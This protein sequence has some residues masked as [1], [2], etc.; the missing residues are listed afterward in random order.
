MSKLKITSGKKISFSWN[1][2]NDKV[3][4]SSTKFTAKDDGLKSMET[5]VKGAVT[6]SVEDRTEKNFKKMSYPKF[7]IAKS[8]KTFKFTY[9]ISSSKTLLSS[10]KFNKKEDC[11]KE[12]EK[13]KQNVEA[14]YQEFL[15]E[16]TLDEMEASAVKKAPLK[17]AKSLSVGLRKLPKFTHKKASPKFASKKAELSNIDKMNASGTAS[18]RTSRGK[19]PSFVNGKFSEEKVLSSKKALAALQSLHHT[20]GFKNAEQEFKEVSVESVNIGRKTTFYRL[21]QY[22]EG[23]PVFG[24]QL[25]VSA[26]E[27]GNVESLSGHYADI[28]SVSQIKFTE[29]MAQE[30]VL[31]DS[32]EENVTLEGLHYYV[33][34]KDKSTLCWKISTT[35]EA[36]FV[37]VTNGSIVKKM[38]TV[39][40]YGRIVSCTGKNLY[41]KEVE[42]PTAYSP[43]TNA[44]SLCDASR[45]ITIYRSQKALDSDGAV[46]YSSSKKWSGEMDA[47]SAFT[48]MIEI[49]DFY[50]SVL[51]RKGADNK[52]K[53]IHVT[54]GYHETDKTYSN[55]F[56]SS[57]STDT[58]IC[59]G[60]GNNYAKPIDVLGHEFTHAVNDSIWNPAYENESGALDEAFADIMGECIQDGIFDLHREDCTSGANR[61][62]ENPGLYGDP[63][64]YSKKEP[65]AT[66]PTESNDYGGVHSNSG[67]INHVAYLMQKKWPTDS[68]A[69]EFAALF[70]KSM[71]YLST[72]SNFLDFRSAILKAAKTMM[73]G[74]SKERAIAE[75]L[76]EVEVVYKDNSGSGASYVLDGYIYDSLNNPIIDAKI[77]MY[78][79]SSSSVYH[80]DYTDSTGRYTLGFV[81]GY[82][83][84]LVVTADGFN[85]YTCTVNLTSS[86]CS[87]RPRTA[88]IKLTPKST[89]S[90]FYSLQG[91][92]TNSETRKVVPGAVVKI[93][94]GAGGMQKLCADQCDVVLTTDED[95]KFFTSKLSNGT[96]SVYF[97]KSIPAEKQCF[98]SYCQ[99]N[100][101][102]KTTYNP[103]VVRT[104]RYFLSSIHVASRDK[105]ADAKKALPSTEILIDRDLNKGSGGKYIYASCGFAQ[106]STPITNIVL[107]KS[108]SKLTWTTKTF[109]S[110]GVSATYT[111]INVDLNE[112]AKGDY[113]Y[114]CY[115]TSSLFSPITGLSVIYDSETLKDPWTTVKW[116]NSSTE[117]D[118]NYKSPKGNPIYFIIKR[119]E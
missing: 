42:F 10:E 108:S 97:Y 56:Y 8:A 101:T 26:D 104:S 46:V 109:S 69:G 68:F 9:A 91:T 92:V 11:L 95:G 58:R 7:V 55:A 118:A 1:N 62:F 71:F 81:K 28:K 18:F 64:R 114:L 4:A 67:I 76:D 15:I 36:Y 25:V 31:K 14:E 6:A 3:V 40:D 107:V 79:G 51:G 39:R 75:A 59:I 96:Y 117:A 33:D 52:G 110:N 38:R 23:I 77:T 27:T 90:S 87:T 60:N 49:Y 66:N 83:Y 24:H 34:D 80:Y 2:T 100:I 21:Q 103:Y 116:V 5:F 65:L 45:G 86:N 35:C 44:Y 13:L 119:T 32:G 94:S 19:H 41:G 85:S 12:I 113:I 99:M 37:N 50:Y 61:S 16:K 48:N 63:D 82:N 17:V 105:Q 20:M 111:R 112:G 73:L 53:P 102:G 74:S 70:Y 72:Y 88:A 98:A 93:V 29:K 89:S 43:A 54:V 78:K 57:R 22:H 30:V 47:I 84:R 106:T 115:T